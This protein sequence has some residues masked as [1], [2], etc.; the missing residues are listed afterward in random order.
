VKNHQ[1]PFVPPMGYFVP[2]I[3]KSTSSGCAPGASGEIYR[4]AGVEEARTP[5][6]SRKDSQ[7]D[8][9]MRPNG[10]RRRRFAAAEAKPYLRDRAEQGLSLSPSADACGIPNSL[11]LLSRRTLNGA[12]TPGSIPK[13]SRISGA[14][15]MDLSRQ[16]NDL[17]RRLRNKTLENEILREAL[18]AAREARNHSA[19]RHRR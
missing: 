10:Q 9:P 17:Q 7:P 13:G 4:A 15:S 16:A 19:H 6:M 11:T 2:E 5:D 12:T 1:Y 18:E 14:E 8:M 3:T